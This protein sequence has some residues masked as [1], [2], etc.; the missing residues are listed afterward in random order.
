VNDAILLAGQTAL[1]LSGVV[2]I[3]VMLAVLAWLLRYIVRVMKQT[4]RL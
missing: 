4:A 2:V 3:F 1:L